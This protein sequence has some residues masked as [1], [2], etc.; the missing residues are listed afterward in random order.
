MDFNSIFQTWKKVLTNP[1][2]ETF[3]AE[4]QES[5]A[6]LSTALV[7]MVLAS[8]I[9]ALL[10]LLQAQ[11]FSSAMGGMG[12]IVGLLPA[13]LQGQFGTI[14]D[15]SASGGAFASLA[16]II[17]GPLSFLIGVGIYHV[18][19]STLGGRGQY[20]RY[21]YLTATFAAPLLI[22]SSI[23]GFVPLAGSCASVI[24]AIYQFV[25]AY[26]ATRAEYGLS[27]G[28]AI[29]VVVAPLLAVLAL[30]VCV[31]AVVLGTVFSAVQQ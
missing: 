27:Q 1:G 31:F 7:W 8:V 29:I 15:T 5:S 2:V 12:Q 22:V 18:I 4:R 23:L 13:E 16:I 21:A 14:T 24:L 10:G 11:I 25:L 28:R 26:Y 19:A 9:A 6:I 3:E 20:G 30:V 17:I